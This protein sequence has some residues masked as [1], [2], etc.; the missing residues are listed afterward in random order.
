MGATLEKVRGSA[1]RSPGHAGDQNQG[2]PFPERFP[3]FPGFVF[4]I[5]SPWSYPERS[6][7]VD[8]LHAWRAALASP[9]G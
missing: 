7:L 1:S 3:H 2:P 8:A 6:P 4:P 5:L 9:H